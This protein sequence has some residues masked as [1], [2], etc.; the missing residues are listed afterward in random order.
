MGRNTRGEQGDVL[1]GKPDDGTA[2]IE[3]DGQ[4]I[5]REALRTFGGGVD[6]DPDGGDQIERQEGRQIAQDRKS[7]LKSASIRKRTA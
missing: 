3:G 4:Q 5:A 7:A 1:A 2:G 6:G